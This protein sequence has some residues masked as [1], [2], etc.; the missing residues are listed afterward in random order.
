M[1]LDFE[2]GDLVRFRDPDIYYDQES[3]ELILGIVVDIV[4]GAQ[5]PYLNETEREI[6]EQ[7]LGSDNDY[8]MGITDLTIHS[9]MCLISWISPWANENNA[10]TPLTLWIPC[11]YIETVS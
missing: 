10:K 9:C 6:V 11:D 2:I 4:Q 8:Y 5:T 1:K 7:I 3:E